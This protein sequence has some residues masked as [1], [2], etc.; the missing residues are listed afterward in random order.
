[1]RTGRRKTLLYM[2]HFLLEAVKFAAFVFVCG[3][4]MR[5]RFQ[6]KTTD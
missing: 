4:L 6:N 3:S 5:F 2:E 1:M